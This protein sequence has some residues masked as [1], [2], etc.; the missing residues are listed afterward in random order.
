METIVKNNQM[1]LEGFR[2][3]CIA[4]NNSIPQKTIDLDNFNF[5]LLNNEDYQFVIIEKEEYDKFMKSDEEYEMP[6]KMTDYNDFY[7][8]GFG[9]DMWQ[10]E[11][12]FMGISYID[13]DED[14]ILLAIKVNGVEEKFVIDLA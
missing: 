12:N 8:E 11:K 1:S 5:F 6:M 3:F 7:E 10:F 2:A 13:A 14:R 9:I 4:H